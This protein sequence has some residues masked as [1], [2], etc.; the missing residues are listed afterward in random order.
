MYI[1]RVHSDGQDLCM[2]KEAY[3]GEVSFEIQVS[4]TDTDIMTQSQ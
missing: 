2:G 4:C 1:D 3:S